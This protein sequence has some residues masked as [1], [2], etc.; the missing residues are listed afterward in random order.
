MQEINLINQ[1]RKVC[2]SYLLLLDKCL[3]LKAISIYYITVSVGQEC[4]H[5]LVECILAQDLS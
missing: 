3:H 1:E 2:I 5:G 4:R